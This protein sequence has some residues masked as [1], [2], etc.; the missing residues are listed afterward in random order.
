MSDLWIPI[1]GMICIALVVITNQVLA[2]RGKQQTH[3]TLQQHLAN[4]GLLTTELLQQLGATPASWKTDLRKGLMLIA[5]GLACV[6]AG[7][8]ADNLLLGIVFGVFPLFIGL[9]FGVVALLNR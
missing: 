3:R 2:A 5:L 7:G 4:G 8:V 6:V 9:A 1:I